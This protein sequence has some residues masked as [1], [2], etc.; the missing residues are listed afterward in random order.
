[1]LK[2][3][4]GER[5]PSRHRDG[6]CHPRR[7]ERVEVDQ[8]VVQD[9]GVV[10]GDEAHPTHISGRGVDLADP[11]G[12]SEAVVPSAQVE[13]LEFIRI[14]RLIFRMLDVDTPDPVA[15]ILEI[16]RSIYDTQHFISYDCF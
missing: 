14:C 1:V 6:S 13:E 5:K 2:L 9:L 11:A 12:G 10:T 15:A 3:G 8:A 4:L 7:F 16:R